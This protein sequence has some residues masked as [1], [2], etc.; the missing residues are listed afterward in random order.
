MVTQE[1]IQ[2]YGIL[3]LPKKPK[4]RHK[5]TWIETSNIPEKIYEKICDIIDDEVDKFEQNCK[6][7]RCKEQ[8]K[9][10]KL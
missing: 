2:V 4:R 9:I 5:T 7:P 1:V 10:N 3:K 6:C 8:R